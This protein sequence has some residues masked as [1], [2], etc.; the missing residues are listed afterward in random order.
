MA[1]GWLLPSGRFTV[2][3]GGPPALAGLPLRAGST[4]T[5]SR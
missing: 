1:I 3:N 4:R 5:G 2:H